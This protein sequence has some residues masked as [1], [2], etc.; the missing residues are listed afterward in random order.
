MKRERERRLEGVGDGRRRD[1]G[2]LGWRLVV[3]G[4]IAVGGVGA[5][6]RLNPISSLNPLG[7]S[8]ALAQSAAPE[9]GA[10]PVPGAA[11]GAINDA[12]I[13]QYAE[14]VL[15]LEPSR[16]AAEAGARQA[17]GDR[18]L[19]TVLCSQPDSVRALPRE[20]RRLAAEYCN[21]SKGLVESVGLTVEAFNAITDAHGVDETLRQ[22]IQTELLRLQGPQ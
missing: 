10:E 5:I 12:A 6:A 21:Q 11:P 7:S 4:A 20:A 3:L 9:A 2:G 19:P 8:V 18:P 1:R 16:Q 13:A 22:R 14:A 15:L 17:M